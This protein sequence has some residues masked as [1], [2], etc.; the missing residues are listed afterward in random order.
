[1][2]TADDKTPGV[3]RAWQRMLSGRRLNIVDPSPLDIEIEDIALGLSRV[4]RWNGQTVGPHGFSVAQHCVVVTEIMAGRKNGLPEPGLLAGLL[5]DAAEYVTSD[6]ISPFKVAIGDS[7]RSVEDRLQEA[8]HIRFGLPPI[9]PADWKREIKKADGISCVA[10]A[11]E[12]AGF[13]ATEARRV[14]GYRG[15]I[16]KLGLSPWEAERARDAFLARFAEL[17]AR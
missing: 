5:H 8:V 11:V 2:N 3:P 4:S 10:E 13:Q 12:L 9:L 1:M 15:R 16:P 17:S 7:Y 14:F 6:L